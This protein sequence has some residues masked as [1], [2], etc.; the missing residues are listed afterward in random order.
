M[1][2]PILISFCIWLIFGSFSTVLIE[3]WHSGRWGIM[4][5]R[6]EC[7]HCKHVL[8]IR[9]LFPIFSYLSSGGQCRYCAT[10][11]PSFYPLAEILMGVIF[12]ILTYSAMIIEIDI[13]SSKMLFLL[14]FW[15]VTGVYILYDM[16][17][18]EI[19]DQIM[20]PAIY[21]L[22]TIPFFSLLF[23]WY[24]EYTF[25]TFHIS[26]F[27]RLFWAFVLYTFF[28]IQI[29]IPGWY[30]LIR[31]K[32][33]K[34]LWSLILSY[35]TFPIIMFVDLFR[36]NKADNELEIPTWI[37]GGDLRIAMFIGL[38]LWTVHGISSFAFA[39]IIG[40]IVWICILIYNA[41]KSKKTESQIPFWPFLGI[42]WIL[43]I[44]FYDKIDI[45][46]SLFFIGQ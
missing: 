29:L 20:V 26:I 36:W 28:Y 1:F 13:L 40:S 7:P 37:G 25:H 4:M 21:I 12:A 2:F 10:N 27:D 42:G 32:D 34:N 46:Y 24:S 6:S 15:F 8:E 31:N 33:W 45:F 5:W 41:T 38:T 11:I 23:T 18:M 39:Y 22:L 44:L 30:F 17:Y 9:D 3:R 43:S 14:G 35:C 19:P 16:R